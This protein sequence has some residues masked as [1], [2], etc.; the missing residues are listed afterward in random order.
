MKTPVMKEHRCSVRHAEPVDGRAV[1]GWLI[2]C[3]CGYSAGN[4]RAYGLA[5]DNGRWHLDAN[6]QPA[7]HIIV[8][9]ADDKRGA[10]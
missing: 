10:R 8:D 5:L 9:I 6:G 4:F 1:E 3:S 2:R 7:A